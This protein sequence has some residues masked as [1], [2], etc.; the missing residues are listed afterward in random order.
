MTQSCHDVKP[1]GPSFCLHGRLHT[2]KEKSA[3]YKIKRPLHYENYR[4]SILPGQDG[5]NRSRYCL[6]G[7]IHAGGFSYAGGIFQSISPPRADVR[8]LRARL[9]RMRVPNVHV[10]RQCPFLFPS[11][12]AETGHSPLPCHISLP[13]ISL[14]WEWLMTYST[15]IVRS[16]IFRLAYALDFRCLNH[17]SIQKIWRWRY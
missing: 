3:T 6:Y 4:A 12:F 5:V 11:A 10:H 17:S 8:A 13:C 14:A 9:C 7:S 15:I 2:G 1:Y 16:S